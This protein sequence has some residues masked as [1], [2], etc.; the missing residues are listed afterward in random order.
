MLLLS[1]S[2]VFLGEKRS[3]LSISFTFF[4]VFQS[5]KEYWLPSSFLQPLS[6]FFLFDPI[7]FQFLPC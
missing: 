3:S 1:L 2:I 5:S 6:C 7:F 4:F